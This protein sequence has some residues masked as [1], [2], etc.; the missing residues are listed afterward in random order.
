MLDFAYA[1]RMMVDCQVRTYD[2]TDHALLAALGEAPRERFVPAGRESLA[3]SDQ[4]IALTP[5]GERAL[6]APM[7][8]A[9]MVQALQVQP[10]ERALDVGCGTGYSSF[11]LSRL[12][13]KVTGLESDAGL[14][15]TAAALLADLGCEGAEVACG[16]LADGWKARAPYNVILVNGSFEVRPDA[17]L[18]QLA[19]GGRLVGV[20]GAGVATRAVLYQ[21]SNSLVSARP[22]F[23]AALPPI[24]GLRKPAGFVF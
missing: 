17:L 16:P 8:L 1:R 5:D 7:F 4:A 6:I 14:A 12:G 18:D 10:G 24:A 22:L 3:Y 9:R 2:V 13:A 11:I 21:R 20:E 19:D 15:E 23:D